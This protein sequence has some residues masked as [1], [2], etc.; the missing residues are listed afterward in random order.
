MIEFPKINTN[1]LVLDKL[2]FHDIPKIVEYAGNKK[3][4]DK[5]LNIPHPYK[6]QDA[7]FWIN[8]A[9]QG[10][11]NKS[12]FTFGIK[13]KTSN[14]FM[15]GIGLKVDNKFNRAELGYW[16]AEK[17]WNLGYATEAVKAILNFGFTELNLN[18]IYATHLE[19]NI[20][21]GKVM[22]KNGMV[23]EGELKEHTKKGKEYKNL[24]Q[25]RLTFQEFKTK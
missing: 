5:T 20:A 2:T 18:K 8:S 13:I 1:R 3:I 12:Q 21:S 14:E 16:I 11:E 9:N 15:G 24:I 6:E 7:I 4:A 17:Y 19:E 22:I 23:K 10:F 25:Y